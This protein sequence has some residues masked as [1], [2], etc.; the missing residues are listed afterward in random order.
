VIAVQVK[1]GV[2]KN[3]AQEVAELASRPVTLPK[4]SDAKLAERHLQQSKDFMELGMTGMAQME[5]WKARE[6]DP[7]HSMD[8][9][10][11]AQPLKQISIARQAE[12]VAAGFLFGNVAII[13]L[14][15]VYNLLTVG[16]ETTLTRYNFFTIITVIASFAL[17]GGLWRGQASART[18]T[19]TAALIGLAFF[20]L[21]ALS[22]GRWLGLISQAGFSGSLLLALTGRPD[23]IRT[24]FAAVVY[25]LGYV[26]LFAAIFLT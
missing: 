13:G 3:R 15:F 16:L 22:S 21:P 12:R 14:I 4:I 19:I 9:P 2:W 20:G 10:E 1:G 8:M 17:G 24:I 18:A 25:I 6:A 5:L 26:G 23:R 11:L 7:L